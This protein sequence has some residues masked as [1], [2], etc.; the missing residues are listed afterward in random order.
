MSVKAPISADLIAEQN[1]AEISALESDYTALGAQ[2]S[3]R[4]IDIDALTKAA[5]DFAV[6]IPSWGVGTGGTRF[7]RFPGL[8]NHA[9]FMK[10]WPTVRLFN[11]WVGQRR[12]CHSISRGT[13]STIFQNCVKRHRD[14]GLVSMR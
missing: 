9:I 6:A 13:R 7:A 14:T 8:V 3:R 5:M 10:S 2:L 1:D 11:N 4:G 12:P